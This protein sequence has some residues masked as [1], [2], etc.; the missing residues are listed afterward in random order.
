MWSFRFLSGMPFSLL[1]SKN[2]VRYFHTRHSVAGHC[3]AAVSN[4]IFQT[5]HS[6]AGRQTVAEQWLSPPA[7]G[8]LHW[9]WATGITQSLRRAYTPA[10]ICSHEGYRTSVCDVK[11]LR[12]LPNHLY[13]C[14][15]DTSG[16]STRK[17]VLNAALK[18]TPLGNLQT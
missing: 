16:S 3:E 5:R 17:P 8:T 13:I 1:L 15:R 10:T 12:V 7:A 18:F 6:V 11:A 14:G 9:G 4:G 2:A